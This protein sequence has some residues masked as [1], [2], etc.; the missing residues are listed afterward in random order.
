MSFQANK[1]ARP[2]RLHC[3]DQ[4]V[5]LK[6]KGSCYLTINVRKSPGEDVSLFIKSSDF[7]KDSVTV[8]SFDHTTHVASLQQV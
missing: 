3:G 2:C 5:K 6:T 4:V 7:A 1:Q 8:H